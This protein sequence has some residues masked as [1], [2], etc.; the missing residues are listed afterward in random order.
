MGSRKDYPGPADAFDRY[1]AAIDLVEG[2]GRKGAAN[3]YTSDN[4]WMATF[5][6]KQGEVA[7]RLG[8][9]DLQD[10]LAEHDTERPVSHGAVMKDFARVP[11]AVV[12][13]PQ[14]LAAVI[15]RAHAH[16]DQLPPK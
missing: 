12:A 8:A 14:Q 3:P 15:R 9:D 16:V 6:G 10:F 2:V 7:I 13:D 4:G 5:L 1:D 11:D